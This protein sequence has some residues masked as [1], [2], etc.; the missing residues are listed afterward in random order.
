MHAVFKLRKVLAGALM[1]AVLVGTAVAGDLHVLSAG[2]IEPGLNAAAAAF[3]KQTGHAVNI[4]F[5]TAPELK[6]R[7][8]TG[9]TFDVV[10][11]PPTVLGE[12]AAAGKLAETRA[13][14]GRVGVGVAVRKG[15]PRPD[16]T[17]LATL[18]QSMLAADALVFNRASTGLYVE[19][20]LKKMHID[21]AVEGRTTRYVDGAAVMLHVIKGRGR[22]I[23]LGAMTEILLYQGKGLELVGPL[24]AEVQNYTSYSAAPLA[25]SQQQE[26]AQTFVSFLAGSVAK[27]LFVAA[28]ITD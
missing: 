21:E 28:G 9:S 3:E 12:F 14:V 17:S 22:E 26:L 25:S 4:T 1:S 24:P 23:G 18:K 15:A 7:M 13:N 11:A 19:G 27:P 8:A 5:N 6:K 10:I 20:L 2:A 16:I